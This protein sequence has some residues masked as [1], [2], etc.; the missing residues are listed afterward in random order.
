MQTNTRI[1]I[2]TLVAAVTC[3]FVTAAL[4]I[5][6]LTLSGGG[7]P[8]PS[9]WGVLAV[10]FSIVPAGLAAV[11]FLVSLIYF[12]RSGRRPRR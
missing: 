12:V 4:W 7:G 11:L 1:A 3:V 8:D 6:A 5:L 9:G 2:G 10:M